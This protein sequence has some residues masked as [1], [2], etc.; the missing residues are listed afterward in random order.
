MA[1]S[2]VPDFQSNCAIVRV[3]FS[4]LPND[5][6]PF[7]TLE[8]VLSG[9]SDFGLFSVGLKES[10]WKINGP[11][12]SYTWRYEPGILVETALKAQKHSVEI[13][14]TIT[15]QTDK[16][17]PKVQLHPCIPTNEAPSFRP[18]P[19]VY[20]STDRLPTWRSRITGNRTRVEASYFEMYQ[21]LFLWKGE[22]SFSFAK[23]HLAKEE[24]HLAFCA[25]NFEAPE[26][27]WWQNATER[28]TKPFI[29][30]ESRDQRHA[31]LH[32]FDD[33]RWASANVGEKKACFHL[34]PYFGDL[35]PGETKTVK[36]A[37]FLAQG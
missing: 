20:S 7:V 34:F 33:A 11:D 27:A 2:L 35:S 23:S 18:D 5:S 36:G 13:Y 32:S 25:D 37:L 4:E 19:D 3:V 10:D 26:W 17:L 8:G 14:Y 9:N 24:V 28:F 1:V 15:N 12:I 21:R 29:A 31:L 6:F 30:L 16:V 22:E